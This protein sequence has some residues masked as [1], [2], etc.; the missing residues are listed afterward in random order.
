[1]TS[2]GKTWFAIDWQGVC[3]RSRIEFCLNN[4]ANRLQMAVP[5]NSQETKCLFPIDREEAQE[6]IELL[7]YW[8]ETGKLITED[9]MTS[10]GK[11]A[12]TTRGHE[13]RLGLLAKLADAHP[14]W[15][16]RQELRPSLHTGDLE[17]LAW[18]GLVERTETNE[19][20]SKYKYRVTPLGLRKALK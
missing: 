2:K 9:D 15:M 13:R 20:P 3:F 14:R 4:D 18:D 19:H 1:M 7:E 10:N 6:M 12:H 17:A 5:V 16:K 8:L 11:L